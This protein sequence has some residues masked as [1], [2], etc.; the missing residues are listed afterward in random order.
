MKRRGRRKKK[1]KFERIPRQFLQKVKE[2]PGVGAKFVEDI[3]STFSDPK[4]AASIAIEESWI[5]LREKWILASEGKSGPLK[6]M[7]SG[8]FG[9]QRLALISALGTIGEEELP[10]SSVRK[11][12][13]RFVLDMT[14]SY[15]IDPTTMKPSTG[16]LRAVRQAITIGEKVGIIELKGNKV[17][18]TTCDEVDVCSKVWGAALSSTIGISSLARA[19]ILITVGETPGIEKQGIP[20]RLHAYHNAKFVHPRYVD[21][22]LFVH[23]ANGSGYILEKMNSLYRCYDRVRLG[24]T[25]PSALFESDQGAK[26]VALVRMVPAVPHS[27]IEDMYGLQFA[28][29][30]KREVTS[31][32]PTP[33]KAVIVKRGDL[34]FTGAHVE[35]L[36]LR[37]IN[38]EKNPAL[39]LIKTIYESFS[40]TDLVTVAQG[41]RKVISEIVSG[42]GKPENEYERK[43]C[44]I[45]HNRGLIDIT[46]EGK[47]IPINLK[48][49]REMLLILGRVIV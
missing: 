39:E 21:K 9:I 33:A 19:L 43:V 32:E 11:Y 31:Y 30:V 17:I 29:A 34:Y 5:A 46:P 45:L 35:A 37:K 2:N 26:F 20:F 40:P 38:L 7:L 18:R 44:R 48:L 6:S 42:E 41:A 47:F 15:Y 14:G 36:K 25:K 8:E 28:S 23:G 27:L 1:M 24:T 49:L 4:L 10:L 13:K 22:T 12:L 16:L 3:I